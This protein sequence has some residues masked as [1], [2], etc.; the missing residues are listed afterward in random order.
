MKAASFA[1]FAVLVAG[2]AYVGVTYSMGLVRHAPP[3]PAMAGSAQ[4]APAANEPG[5]L[6]AAADMRP[7]DATDEASC[8]RYGQSVK[9]KYEAAA[10]EA[11]MENPFVSG[12]SM[13]AMAA[14]SA[15][16]AC[17]ARTRPLRLCDP[18]ERSA[19]VDRSRPYFDRIAAFETLMGISM[20]SP[21]FILA[22]ADNPAVPMVKGMLEETRRQVA[23][24]HQMVVAAFHELAVKGLIAEADFGGLFGAPEAIKPAFADLPMVTPVCPTA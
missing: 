22:G 16:V 20:N 14:M 13:G 11:A 23:E 17:E 18:A 4:A 5:P 15:D 24:N 19:L 6:R 10:K 9:K 12:P 8:L 21:G 7:F 3:A 1:L 2:V